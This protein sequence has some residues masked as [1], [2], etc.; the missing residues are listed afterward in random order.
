[1]CTEGFEVNIA[2]AI[3]NRTLNDRV[4]QV[5]YRTAGP[6]FINRRIV[7]NCNIFDVRKPRNLQ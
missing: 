1:M 5:D 7:V 2:G 4:H 6:N 3:V